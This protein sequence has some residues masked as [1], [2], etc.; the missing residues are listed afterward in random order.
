MIYIILT[1]TIVIMITIVCICCFFVDIMDLKIPIHFTH[2]PMISPMI[3]EKAYKAVD[4]RSSVS[5]IDDINHTMKYHFNMDDKVVHD[6]RQKEFLIE[7]MCRSL[8]RQMIQDGIVE[9]KDT[10]DNHEWHDP[11]RNIIEMRIKVYKEQ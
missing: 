6:I 9:I 8:T 3:I 2:Y 7:D 10:K 5:Y 11:Y 4:Y 1:F